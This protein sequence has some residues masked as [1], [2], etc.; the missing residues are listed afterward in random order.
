[1]VSA[2]FPANPFAARIDVRNQF[3]PK[4]QKSATETLGG[5][6]LVSAVECVISY[7]DEIQFQRAEI[8]PS[9]FDTFKDEKAEEKI[10][11]KLTGWGA[12]PN[13]E[14]TK[15]LAYLRLRRNH[16]AH[17]NDDPH[18][19]LKAVTANYGNLLANHW[20]K[21]P[22]VL[23]DLQF[24]SQN[25]LVSTEKEAFS[26]INLCRIVMESYDQLLV[27]TI[28]QRNL[29]EFELKR[30]MA[31]NK[32]IAGHKIEA[33]FRKFSAQFRQNYGASVVMTIDEVGLVWGMD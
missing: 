20:A 21:Q 14:L 28:P 2:T 8:I 4:F 7:L 23:S 15:T 1:M 32:A 12:K 31:S 26:I 13:L 17:A 10:S 18:A 24:T 9:A 5:I 16:I 6:A 29:E 3:L 33:R 25:Y 11:H 22:S 19:S 27:S 30:F